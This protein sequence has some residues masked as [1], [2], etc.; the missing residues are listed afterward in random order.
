QRVA[1]GFASA[2]KVASGLLV[3]LDNLDVEHPFDESGDAVV[4]S[5][6]P[7]VANGAARFNVDRAG[8]E[9]TGARSLADGTVLG[10]AGADLVL[11]SAGAKSVLFAGAASDKTTEPRIAASSS[12]TLVTFRRG[13]LGGQ[14]LYGWLGSD[15]KA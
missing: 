3:R 9:L 14:L 4:R 1:V 8:G 2:P 12:G 15:G 11:S 6:S 13:G 5:S 10:F 7:R